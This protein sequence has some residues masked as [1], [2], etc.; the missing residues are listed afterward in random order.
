MNNKPTMTVLLHTVEYDTENV[1]IDEIAEEDLSDMIADDIIHMGLKEGEEVLE[2]EDDDENRLPVTVKWKIVNPEVA[3][4]KEEY[5][6]EMARRHDHYRGINISL[7][8]DR[9]NW[10]EVAGKLADVLQLCEAKH[11]SMMRSTTDAKIAVLQEYEKLKE[12]I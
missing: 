1:I 10:I 5:E 11:N 2:L 7:Q 8:Q 9:D 3:I 12:T 6:E 4:L